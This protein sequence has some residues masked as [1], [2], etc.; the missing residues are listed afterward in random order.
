[1]DKDKYI[2]T[3]DIAVRDYELD[4]E[5]IVNNANYLHYL[6][7]TRHDFCKHC[8]MSFDEMRRQGII[9]VLR[10]VEIEYLTSLQS[11]D[12]MTSCLNMRREGPKFMFQQD[13]Y[14]QHGDAV[15]KASVTVVAL[16][17]GRLSRGEILAKAFADYL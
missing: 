8:G 12:V 5:G 16:E 2:Y 3:T 15:V 11:G 6:E 1:M 7:L 13:I 10:K 17:N 14:N 9:P 4:A